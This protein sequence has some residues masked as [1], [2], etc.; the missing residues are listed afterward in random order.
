MKILFFAFLILGSG[1]AFA[2]A[3]HFRGYRL[4]EQILSERL[5]M[6]G[7]EIFFYDY[8]G[9]P[10]GTGRNLLPLMGSRSSPGGGQI[11]F[12]N[13][14]P[15]SVSTLL[16]YLVLDGFSK[17]VGESCV[18]T[19]RAFSVDFTTKLAELCRWPAESA[20][21]EKVMQDFWLAV[22]GYDAPKSEYQAWRDFF[23]RSS[24]SSES[25]APTVAAMTLALVY[26]PHFLLN[27]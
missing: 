25:A 8:L 27:K 18:T 15:N 24:Y 2:E 21:S 6:P 11:E 19:R 7:Y 13:G 3:G 23:L 5:T 12:R 10:Y 14:E 16:W 26:N 17:D 4:V 22:M 1:P 9:G 20:K